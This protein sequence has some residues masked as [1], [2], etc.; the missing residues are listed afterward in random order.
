MLIALDT[1]IKLDPFSS[2]LL[3]LAYIYIGVNVT[4]IIDLFLGASLLVIIAE[5]DFLIKEFMSFV[6]S[7]LVEVSV[8]KPVL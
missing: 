5:C 6:V 7:S 4:N 3:T 2:D 1:K 8:N